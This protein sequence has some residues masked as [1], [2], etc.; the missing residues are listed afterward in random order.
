MGR[1]KPPALVLALVIALGA[2]PGAS[3]LQAEAEV[4]P[5]ALLGQWL[6]AIE[7]HQPGEADAAVLAVAAWPRSDLR[8][9]SSDIQVLVAVVKNPASSRFRIQALESD[10]MPRGQ[11]VTTRTLRP[12]DRAVLD[13][14]AKQV[15]DAGP[16]LV[17]RRAVLLH[18][19]AIVLAGD[20]VT[21]SAGAA[22]SRAPVKMLIGDGTSAGLEG[23]SVHWELARLAAESVTPD[24]KDDPFVRD[25]YRATIALGQSHESFDAAQLQHGLRLF[26]DDA[27]ML[28]LAGC[29]REAF[30]SPMFQVFARSVNSNRSQG[31]A[32]GRFRRVPI[33]SEADELA[34]AERYYRRAIAA[35]PALHEARLRLGRVLARRG[36]S[37]EAATELQLTVDSGLDSTLEYFAQLFLAEVRESLQQTDAARAALHRAAEL[38]PDARVPHLQLARLA[39]ELGDAAEAQ[40]SLQ[41]ALAEPAGESVDPWLHYRAMQGRDAMTWLDDVRRAWGER[42]E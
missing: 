8:Q 39:R 10:M 37:A 1:M 38:T 40:A 19:D 3:G 14:L 11:Q 6:S 23:V 41:R 33:E 24:P 7:R 18:T 27:R 30:A 15:R 25:W 12:A 42:P 17:L 35:D 9:L 31:V 29:E 28:L 34:A 21:A 2:S 4:H 32:I 20:V 36:R 26:P 13:A 22:P 5:L 16:N